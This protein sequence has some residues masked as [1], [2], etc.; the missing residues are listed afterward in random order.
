MA[1]ETVK[2]ITGLNPMFHA[3]SERSSMSM[4][5]FDGSPSDTSNDTAVPVQ[6]DPNHHFYQHT[7]NNPMP[8]PDLRIKSGLGDISSIDNVQQNTA[9]V[10]TGNK[11]G[12]TA[13]LQRVAS[14]EHLQKRIRGGVVDS[15][16]PPS[17]GEQ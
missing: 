12:Q 4:S 8:T 16:G 6:D 14:L 17:N 10:V 1:E 3:M 7:S 5:S 13:S 9:A 11:M 2:R 15:S